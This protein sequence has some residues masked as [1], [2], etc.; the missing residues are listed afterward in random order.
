MAT[1]AQTAIGITRLRVAVEFEA[2]QTSAGAFVDAIN[3]LAWLIK[4]A[5]AVAAQDLSRSHWTV[6]GASWQDTASY[7]S[8]AW[9]QTRLLVVRFGSPLEAAYEIGRTVLAST[10]GLAALVY[11]LKRMFGLDLEL[12]THRERLRE[13]FYDA[14]VLADEAQAQSEGLSAK[15]TEAIDKRTVPLTIPREA[16]LVDED[17]DT[18][19]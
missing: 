16:E 8:T 14:K 12:R 15:L 5:E 19:A 10:S 3:T 9:P 4:V 18:A 7:A 11:G 1:V 6:P 17:E 2:R 13:R